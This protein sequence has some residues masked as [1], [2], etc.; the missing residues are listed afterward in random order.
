MT[1]TLS[2]RQ[3]RCPPLPRSHGE[4]DRGA[5]L[6]GPSP[7]SRGPRGAWRAPGSEQHAKGAGLLDVP[8]RAPG[9]PSMGRPGGGVPSGVSQQRPAEASQTQTKCEKEEDGRRPRTG[10]GQ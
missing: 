2:P 5:G 9:D 3:G 1:Q 8:S 4:G 6:A 10:P 7:S